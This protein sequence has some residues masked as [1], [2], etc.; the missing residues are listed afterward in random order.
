MRKM[1]GCR[2][3][4]YLLIFADFIIFK[5]TDFSHEPLLEQCLQ[6]ALFFVITVVGQLFYGFACR[7]QRQIQIEDGTWNEA[8]W[9]APR[10]ETEPKLNQTDGKAKWKSR[11]KT[12]KFLAFAIVM[13]VFM[14]ASAP[15][16]THPERA[17][18]IL[19]GLILMLLLAI[20]GWQN[21]PRYIIPHAGWMVCLPALIGL[22]SLWMFN[23]ERYAANS[24][25]T[26]ANGITPM[27]VLLFNSA[28]ILAYALLTGFLYWKRH[29]Y[30]H[31]YQ[32]WKRKSESRPKVLN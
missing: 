7:R 6:A 23:A 2:M 17:L 24:K 9:S 26:A 31:I 8:E 20:R 28:V 14:G 3:V 30:Q 4:I 22:F 27:V 16:A 12:A 5:K 15:W 1:M 29:W 21:R 25:L 18:L 19:A 13:Y 32:C 10:R 11:L